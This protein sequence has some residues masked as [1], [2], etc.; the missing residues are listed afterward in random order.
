MAAT[1]IYFNRIALH[2]SIS[3]YSLTYVYTVAPRERDFDAGLYREVVGSSFLRTFL[4]L[5][6]LMLKSTGP[7][8]RSNLCGEGYK[9][10]IK[11]STRTGW[12]VKPLISFRAHLVQATQIFLSNDD[13]RLK[14]NHA[15]SSEMQ[16]V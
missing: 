15:N 13:D 2:C 7:P 9:D 8:S 12:G 3:D 6:S 10:L 5:K 16:A 11:L 1:C 4:T 14:G